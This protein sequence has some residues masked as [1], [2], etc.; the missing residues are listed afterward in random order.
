MFDVEE[1]AMKTYKAAVVQ[2]SSIPFDP[3]A[4]ADK[5]AK[6]VFEVAAAGARLAVFP[7]VF[8]GGYP[9]GSSFG[10]PVGLRKPE[11]VTPSGAITTAPST[12]TGP[13]W[14]CWSR[15]CAPPGCSW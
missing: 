8:L 11:D 9:K 10:A 5:A 14:P 2:A 15:R 4:S 1:P 12:L 3:G 13:N 6:L 7:E